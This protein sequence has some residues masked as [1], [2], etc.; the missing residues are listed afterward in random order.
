[1]IQEYPPITIAIPTFQRT[2]KLLARVTE[3][4]PQMEQHDV[5]LI[6]DNASSNFLPAEHP[7]LADKRIRLYRNRTNIGANANIVKC[8]ERCE[9]EWMWLL[10]DDDKIVS[11]A[12]A[13]IRSEIARYPQACYINFT[14]SG[15]GADRTQTLEVRGL[16]EFISHN[17]GFA[18]TLLM[19][20]NIYRM[21]AI[22]PHMKFAHGAIWTNAQHIAPVLKAVEKG[23]LAVYSAAAIV[24]WSPPDLTE[25]WTV[26]AV[27]N[28][29]HLTTV[30]ESPEYVPALRRLIIGGLPRIEYLVL[31]LCYMIKMHG[32]ALRVSAYAQQILDAYAD[33]G[34]SSIRFRAQLLRYLVCFPGLVV[35]CADFAYRRLRGKTLEQ[36][37]QNRPFFFYL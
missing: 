17:D 36:V 28:L 3:L 9:S 6:S 19:S 22:L 29:V 11:T 34:G 13:N 30:L 37:L 4:L 25:N 1:M 24:S 33:Y 14:A 18:N 15:M 10:G 2:S 8:F 20:N 16:G 23:E 31:Q 27:F 26:A 35:K 32:D 7:I 5:L 21:P 12:L